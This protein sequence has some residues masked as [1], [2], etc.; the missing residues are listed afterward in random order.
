[1]RHVVH[2]II[3]LFIPCFSNAQ[4]K[5]WAPDSLAYGL[6]MTVNNLKDGEWKIYNTEDVLISKGVFVNNL[7][8]G[9]W[10]NYYQNGN[11]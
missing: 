11:I 6:G 1:M 10:N 2:L 5:F 8:E 3:L 4:E 7:R 9:I